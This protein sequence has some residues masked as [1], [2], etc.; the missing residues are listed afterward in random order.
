MPN[1]D[2][3][4]NLFSRFLAVQA[5]YAQSG[6]AGISSGTVA[7]GRARRWSTFCA[8]VAAVFVLCILAV[9]VR[10]GRRAAGPP[11]AGF[12]VLTTGIFGLTTELLIVYGYQV[13]FGFVYRDIALLTGLFMLGLSC[14]AILVLRARPARPLRSLMPAEAGQV[15]FILALPALAG[16]AWASPV[17]YAVAAVAAGALT[18]AVFPLA[19]FAAVRAG[20]RPQAAA[21]WFDAADHGGAVIGAA[22]AGLLLLPAVGLQATAA[23]IALAKAASLTGLVTA[24]RPGAGAPPE[25]GG[26]DAGGRPV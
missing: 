17:L 20:V 23:L 2:R 5:A 25:A 22:T 16:A 1:T 8:A 19:A 26:L 13:T 11:A 24:G 9:R 7:G 4:P 6:V 15:A 3:H 21:G 12:V 18:G 10:R 14:G